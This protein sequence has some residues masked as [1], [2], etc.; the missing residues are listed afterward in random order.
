M[1]SKCSPDHRDDVQVDSPDVHEAEDSCFDWNDG[2]DYPARCHRIWNE[3][4][5]HEKH[6]RCPGAKATDCRRPNTDEL[7]TINRKRKKK[8]LEKDQ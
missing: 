5:G 2:E 3:N 8:D 7:E 1:F 6:N 4:D